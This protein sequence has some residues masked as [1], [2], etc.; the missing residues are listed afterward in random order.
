[1][2]FRIIHVCYGIKLLFYISGLW[3]LVNEVLL[4]YV[5]PKL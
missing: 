1:M 5:N 4:I 2:T 3:N